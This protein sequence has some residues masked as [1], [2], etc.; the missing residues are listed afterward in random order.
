[1]TNTPHHEDPTPPKR[2]STLA[3]DRLCI[4][5]GYNLT[6]QP[7]VRE[8]HYDM[9]IVRCPECGTVASLQEYPLL[10]RWA[11][12][13]ATV[14]AAGWFFFI[15]AFT[16]ATAGMIV[17]MSDM[18]ANRASKP[19]ATHLAQRQY[20]DLT[21]QQAQGTLPQQ[22]LWVIQQQQPVPLAILDSAWMAKQDFPA[23]LAEVGGW[24]AVIDLKALWTWGWLA[25]WAL[26]FGC[27]WAVVL[28]HLR[29]RWLVAFGLVPVA[30]AAA[31]VL[32]GHVSE[33]NVFGGSSWVPAEQFATQRVGLPVNF[34]TVAFALIPLSVALVVGR[35]VLRGVIRALLP[36][37]LRGALALL[38]TADGLDPPGVARRN[39]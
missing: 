1:M 31:L 3:G 18:A 24:A 25:L 8:T 4:K 38:W 33:S 39:R 28:V 7:V 30:L 37:R 13:W 20:E 22:S 35:S 27:A 16:F 32:F 19:Y 26:P 14:L 9:L 6:G 34:A 12:R 23:I 11:G 2:V 29:R 10:G 21:D 15:L 36:P 17:G 5:C